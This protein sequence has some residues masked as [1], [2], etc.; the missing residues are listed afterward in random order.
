MGTDYEGPTPEI[1]EELERKHLIKVFSFVP[2]TRMRPSIVP[3][4]L[5]T[6]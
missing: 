6:S 1:N 2:K 3:P 4:A 5:Q